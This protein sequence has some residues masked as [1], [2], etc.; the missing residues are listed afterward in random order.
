MYIFFSWHL[1]NLNFSIFVTHVYSEYI[2]V[3][4]K[5][6]SDALN[7]WF[8]TKIIKN[9]YLWGTRLGERVE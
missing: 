9:S 4:Q 3:S 7:K 2:Q 5:I 8:N 1:L 6:Y